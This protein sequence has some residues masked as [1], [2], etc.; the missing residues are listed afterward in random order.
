MPAVTSPPEKDTYAGY[1]KWISR[2]T[3]W[4]DREADE[5]IRRGLPIGLVTHLQEIMELTDEE[6]AHVIGRSRS[7][8]SRYR[9]Q[10]KDL[11]IPEAERALRFTRL[12]GL[13]G[14]TFGSLGE[15]RR[16]MRESNYALGGP[17]PIE[18]AETDPGAGL[19]RDLLVGMQRG[20]PL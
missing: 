4:D 10:G 18:M 12:L 16:W 17:T 5:K 6:A 15:A 7:T 9:R 8:Y 19:V 11:G 20:F 14:E 3:G 2:I 13:A 1:D